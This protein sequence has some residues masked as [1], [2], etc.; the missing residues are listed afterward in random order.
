MKMVFKSGNRSAAYLFFGAVFL[1]EPVVEIWFPIEL[2]RLPFLYSI[3]GVFVWIYWHYRDKNSELNISWIDILLFVLIIYNIADIWNY[4]FFVKLSVGVVIY[5]LAKKAADESKVAYVLTASGCLQFFLILMQFCDCIPSNHSLFRLTGSFENPGPLGGF[6]AV[7]LIATLSNNK[8]SNKRL[9]MLCVVFL[10]IGVFLSN[11]RA[12]WLAVLIASLYMVMQFMSVRF[13]IQVILVLLLMIF[14]GVFSLTLY[15]TKSAKGRIEI[16]KVCCVMITDSPLTGKG[17]GSFQREYMNYQSHYIQQ[18]HSL[19][20]NKLLG[21]NKYAF[22]EYLHIACEQG[23]I[24]LLI[25]LII[26]ILLY[27]KYIGQSSVLFPCFIAFFVFSSFSYPG[28][29]FLLYSAFALLL[30][31]L[32]VNVCPIRICNLAKVNCCLCLIGGVLVGLLGY[33]WM[34]REGMEREFNRFLYGDDYK[35]ADY[36]SQHYSSVKNSADFIFRYAYTLYLK[37]EYELALP[38]MKQAIFLYPTT[39]KYCDLGN[40]YKSLGNLEFAEKTYKKA[41]EL[42]P[43]FIYPRYCLFLLYK[44]N[45]KQDVTG[46]VAQDILDMV[47]KKDN[48]EIREIKAIVGSYLRNN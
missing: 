4:D 41:I 20:Q 32:S 2:F 17:V 13:R 16:W 46:Q 24:G 14:A 33:K 12:A 42:L 7:S 45:G 29:V 48:E 35:G 36:I 22:N 28:D 5:L 15:K 10:I 39:D 21:N 19:S 11:S 23:F 34:N 40:I 30:G 43:H 31:A 37:G 26:L 8:Y 47:P 18:N 25:I 9:K 6:M 38:I 1:I 3:I 27:Q 44:E